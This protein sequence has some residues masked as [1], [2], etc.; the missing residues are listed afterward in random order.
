MS[1]SKITGN[2]TLAQLIRKQR[3]AKKKLGTKAPRCESTR[4]NND[5]ISS[6]EREN[7]HKQFLALFHDNKLP[8]IR[9][10]G[11]LYAKRIYDASHYML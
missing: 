2:E 8:A 6:Q 11:R 4:I 5:P 7:Y 1:V 3:L 10:H 9:I